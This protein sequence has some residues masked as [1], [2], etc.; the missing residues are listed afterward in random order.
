MLQQRAARLP[1]VLRQPEEDHLQSD[2]A[3]TLVARRRSAALEQPGAGLRRAELVP[4]LP[5][6]LQRVAQ[7]R[8]PAVLGQ[9][10]A[11]LLRVAL[12]L[13]LVAQRRRPA[14]LLRQPAASPPQV[15]PEPT[16]AA[17]LQRVALQ[18][19]PAQ[20]AVPAQLEELRR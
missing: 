12:A 9:R 5:V 7:R 18:L 2:P 6:L 20:P 19:R 10:A 15:E 11:S 13:T 14:A 1:A 3:L 8:R 17:L 16:L 4:P